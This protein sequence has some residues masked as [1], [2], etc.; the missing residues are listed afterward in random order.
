MSTPPQVLPG[1]KAHALIERDAQVLSPSYTRGYP[2]VIDRGSGSRVWD[3]DGNEFIDFTTGIAVTATGHAHPNVVKAIQEQAE[4]FIHMSGTDFYYPAQIEMAER[5]CS[6][7]PFSGDAM[8]F[9]GNSGAEAIEAAAKLARYYTER[10]RFIAFLRAFHGRTMGALSFT[11]S[12]Y[13]QRK[14]VFPLVP[15]ITHVPYPDAYRPI[16]NPAGFEDYGERVV[17]YI[18][19]VIFQTE[20]PPTEVAG[21]LVEPIQGEGGYIVPPDGFFPALRRLCDKYEILLIVDEVQ[22]GMGRTGKWWAVEHWGVEPDIVCTAKGIASGMPLSAIIARREIMSTWVPGAHAST[23]GGNPVSCAAGVATFDLLKGGLI[24]NAAQMGAYL[25]DKLQ[26]VA[27]RHPSIGQ[28]RGKGLM[29]G[30]EFVQ[31]RE[32]RKPAQQLRDRV[33]DYAFQAGL[34]LLG[35]GTSTLR[36]VPPLNVDQATIDEALPILEHAIAHAEEDLLD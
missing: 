4:R 7:A 16:L 22:T 14:D 15:G 33:V 21:I 17:D 19:N 30:T 26:D 2:F 24:D 23:F 1:P 9:F 36:I 27:Q 6:V 12:K 25:L 3:V 8:V 5:L 32:T 34:L 29:I 20:V 31:N 11:A 35:C 10:P 13:V 18:E 28:V